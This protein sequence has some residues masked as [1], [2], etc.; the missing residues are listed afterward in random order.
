M[1]S[2]KKDFKLSRSSKKNLKGVKESVNQLVERSIKKS[3]HDFGIPQ[4]GGI[5][6]PQEQNNLYHRK[7]NVTNLDGFKKKSYHQSGWAFDIFLYDEHG[8]CWDCKKSYKEIKETIFKEFEIMK[9][10]GLFDENQ[11]IEWGGDWSNWK[12][13][14]DLPHFQI[15]TR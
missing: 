1:G 3:V 15:V 4:Y 11:F 8:A 12:S 7:P 9:A 2:S 6:T 14:V 10:E 13:P 5:R